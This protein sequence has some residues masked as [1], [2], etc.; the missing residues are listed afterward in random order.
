MFRLRAT[1]L[2][3]ELKD[4]D[5]RPHPPH[6]IA[7]HHAAQRLKSILYM[8]TPLTCFKTGSGLGWPEPISAIFHLILQAFR[9]LGVGITAGGPGDERRDG[10]GG[11]AND[12]LA[13]GVHQAA[14][15]DR[16]SSNR[17]V[18]S[19]ALASDRG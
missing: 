7:M 18:W 14:C 19:A 9:Q 6:G 1:P 16:R 4:L 3:A 10:L 12:R 5:L 11:L 15:G 8:L 17:L 2:F 13:S